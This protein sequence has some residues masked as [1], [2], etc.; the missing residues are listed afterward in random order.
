[1]NSTD[2]GFTYALRSRYLATMA[3]I[4]VLLTAALLAYV[5]ASIAT[6]K[7]TVRAGVVAQGERLKLNLEETIDVMRGH[8][9]AMQRTI[10]HSLARPEAAQAAASAAAQAQGATGADGGPADAA[11]PDMGTLH[12][13][14]SADRDPGEFRRHLEAA[15]TFLPIAGANHQWHSE[16]QWSYFL[17]AGEHWFLIYP[18]LP[19]EELLRVTRA[20]DLEAALKELFDADSTRPV[21]AAGP[22]DNRGREM[23]WTH[24]YENASG[25]GMMVTLLAPVYYADTY[26]GVVGTDITL[27]TLDVQIREHA[28]SAGRALI[29][30][31]TGTVL[32]DTGDALQNAKG[33]VKF[34][35][36]FPGETAGGEAWF[37]FTL[38]NI[39]WTL[40]VRL[41]QAELLGIVIA[42][43]RAYFG[44]ALLLFMALI[45]LGIV[46]GQLY[47][48][49]A[50]HLARFVV[51]ADRDPTPPDVPGAWRPVFDQ[52]AE[53]ARERRRLRDAEQQL[54]EDLEQKVEE[55]TRELSTTIASLQRAQN[56]A[57]RADRLGSLGAQVADVAN[58]L[59]APLGRASSAAGRLEDARGALESALRV[60]LRKAELEAFV[61]EVATLGAVLREE[62]GQAGGLVQ[63]FKQLA[64]DRASERPRAF[65][66][67]EV[68][69]NV[70]AVR[71]PALARQGCRVV[72]QIDES[73]DL[74]TY[75]GTLGQVLSYLLEDTVSR[76][77]AASPGGELRLAAEV[78]TDVDGESIVLAIDDSSS[79]A[80]SGERE[81][82]ARMLVEQRLDGRLDIVSDDTGTRVRLRLPR[83]VATA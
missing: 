77:R 7:E 20:Q 55:R 76:L 57:L 30:D 14:P 74:T 17:D 29:V 80:E 43:T 45:V 72:N 48:L 51:R 28:P 32:A 6:E 5:W 60:G 82:P 9:F 52:V 35:T 70:L 79:G 3:V 25:K 63:R 21:L 44:F 16:F 50:L 13:L 75:A 26:V 58:E 41:E 36:L 2:P 66:L 39:P 19:V 42:D 4:A 83:R 59:E 49:P 65:R 24:A 73:L 27:K 15:A 71:G 64:I 53:A 67:R 1:M 8:A 11:V 34:S 54:A 37:R 46:Q 12:M 33:P 81:E 31:A 40:L 23:V 78:V 56:D 18:E 61:G 38:D 47:A 68:A 62:I 10:E 69:E 22:H